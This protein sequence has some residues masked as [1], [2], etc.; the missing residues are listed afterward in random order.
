MLNE[1]VIFIHDCTEINFLTEVSEV[2]FLY[3]LIYIT[4]YS[5]LCLQKQRLNTDPLVHCKL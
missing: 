5:P 1:K 2:L 4:S 3:V